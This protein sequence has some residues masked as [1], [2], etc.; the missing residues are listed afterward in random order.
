MLQRNIGLSVP[1]LAQLVNT[2]SGVSTISDNDNVLYV[3]HQHLFA[4]EF[5]QAHTAAQQALAVDKHCTG[6]VL[7]LAAI[8]VE[9]DNGPAAEQLCRLVRNAGVGSCWL[10][11]LEARVALL[12][13]DQVDA[14]QAALK[15]SELG[16][17]DP[18]IANQLGVV[19]SRTG[20]H[21]HAVDP[22][23]VAVAG[24]PENPDYRYNYAI[25]LQFAGQLAEAERQFSK[26]VELQPTHAKGWMALAQLVKRAD[27][28][29]TQILGKQFEAASDPETK[30]ILGHALARF[31]ELESKWDLSLTWLDRA[32]R[33]KA[34]A[35]AH[36]RAAAEGLS[37][38]AM[39]A[40][41][42]P[43]STEPQ[44]NQR[45]I[46]IVGMPR[47]GTTL[48]E[49]IL[50][51]HPEVRSLGELSDFAIELK[52]HVQTPGQLVLDPALLADAA[53]AP[54]LSP[55][56][57]AY[58]R[59]ISALDNT[60]PHVVDKMPFNTFFAPAILKALPG[61][62]IICLRRSPFDV[63]FANYRQLF[64]TGF[65]YY[66]YAYDFADCAHFVA[67]FER[68]A[69]HFEDTLP[70]ARFLPVRY[71]EIVQDQRGQ[72][73]RLLEFCGLEWN[74]ACMEF[75]TNN[76]PVATASSVQVRS[77]IYTSSLDK[78]RR[79]SEGSE[80]ALAEL[81]R[82]GIAP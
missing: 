75:H 5:K 50:T 70:P 72:T 81:G 76:Q 77:P 66:S 69:N 6:A 61:A 82:Y 43:L 78:W 55:V 14:R 26:L 29:W 80:R 41:D 42:Q 21:E 1:P 73:E 19:L 12:K 38:A 37:T 23:A 34:Q 3:A 31:A 28:V 62:R 35:I 68:M 58:L 74:D 8:A 45:P 15:A 7:V 48:A 2:M 52:R 32:K 39:A 51:S 65:S 64:A 67:Q 27:P 33:D 17:H 40:A 20:R 13:Q 59:R 47:S 22:F 10:H 57:E 25:A 56:G 60:T 16:T 49:R 63:L 46:F 9:H 53:Q 4:G 24:E 30:L 71:E 36:D 44:G 79:Y 18:H 11:V 54:D